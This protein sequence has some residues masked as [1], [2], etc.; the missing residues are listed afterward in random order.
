MFSSGFQQYMKPL[1]SDRCY[2]IKIKSLSRESKAAIFIQCC[3]IHE[4]HQIF[5]SL[6]NMLVGLLFILIS[7]TP[8][9]CHLSLIKK[10]SMNMTSLYGCQIFFEIHWCVV[11][12]Y[13]LSIVFSDTSFFIYLF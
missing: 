6:V 4:L 2:I 8:K 5:S 12:I 1:V 11:S 9:L 10:I 13:S 3:I 7:W